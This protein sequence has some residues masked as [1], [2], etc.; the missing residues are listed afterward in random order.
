MATNCQVNFELTSDW[1]WHEE[2]K[3]GYPTKGYKILLILTNTTCTLKE[4]NNPLL[5]R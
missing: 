1:Q 4:K 2:G 3:D 5:E